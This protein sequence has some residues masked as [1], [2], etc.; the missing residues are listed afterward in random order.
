MRR[1]LIIT[2]VPATLRAF[3]LPYARHFANQGWQVDAMARGA[4]ECAECRSTF[5][6]V[7][8]VDWTRNPLD[9]V[10][11]ARSVQQVR[12]VVADEGYDL[13]HVHTP[14]AAFVARAA[15][16]R[17]RA[18]GTPKVI[19]TAHG[20]H[21]HSG[22]GLL[23]NAVFGAL[24]RRAGA[25]TD[26]LVVINREDALAAHRMH[27]LP[28]D[29]IHTMTG[30][31]VDTERYDPAQVS[32]QEVSRVRAHLGLPPGTPL[33]LVLGE[34]IRRKRH[35]DVIDALARLSDPRPHLLLAGDGPLLET[36]RAQAL[37]RGIVRRVHF[38]GFRRDV[39]ALVRAAAAVVLVSEQEGLPR[40][41]LEALCLERPVIGTDIRGTRELLEDGAGWLVPVG[42]VDELARA[43]EEVIAAPDDA[44]A[45]G[46]RG[47]Q[48]VLE[49][50]DQDS[51]LRQH[52]R[53]YERAI[54][55]SGA[56]SPA[57]RA[58]LEVS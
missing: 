6:R 39:P 27:L 11:I 15:L 19:Y 34:F 16:R 43:M 7:C 12:A 31:G 33:F 29:H 9:L 21:F 8:D 32:E 36:V 41:V 4:T 13:V 46:L 10:G 48:K 30:I 2:T 47:R 45:R 20:F 35:R 3:L 58:C 55:S 57:G 49:G 50:Y 22:R 51:I 23:G 17:M 1:L 28:P 25:W 37:R 53:L 24:E 54:Q 18:T 5:H 56:T 14:I 38:L 40:S 26:E 42:D 52:E 44:L